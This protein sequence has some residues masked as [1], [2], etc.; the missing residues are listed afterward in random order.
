MPTKLW[1]AGARYNA[2]IDEP[3]TDVTA[4]T[5]RPA[6][7]RSRLWAAVR[8]IVVTGAILSVVALVCPGLFGAWSARVE[9]A[10]P[11]SIELPWHWQ[12]SVEKDPPGLAAV[13]ATTDDR[14]PGGGMLV[15]IAN[16]AG[17]AYDEVQP[18]EVVGRNGV[19][20]SLYP[21]D[22]DWLAGETLH[23]SP[24]GRYLAMPYLRDETTARQGPTIVDLTTGEARV[25][26]ATAVARHGTLAVLGWRP[27]GG[28]LLVATT[29]G[30]TARLALLD[31]TSG[32]STEL[33]EVTAPQMWRVA[34]SPDGRRVA[35]VAGRALHLVDDRGTALWSAPLPTGTDLAGAGAF[36]P[37]GTR[38]ALAYA[39]PCEPSCA[40]GAAEWGVTYVDSTDGTPAAGPELPAVVGSRI[41][42]VGWSARA[43]GTT[44]LVVVRYLP[45]P[46]E[47]PVQ[48]PDGKLTAPPIDPTGDG[49][50]PA[51]LCELAPGGPARLLLDAPHEVTDL[52]VAVELVRA[53]RFE[54]EPSTPSLLPIEPGRL[55]P[56]DVA[57]ASAVV[58]GLAVVVGVV[59]RLTNR[60]WP[61]LR[62]LRPRR[63]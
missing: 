45:D 22:G 21:G 47:P 54:G 60:P 12:G 42:A 49:T 35:F 9:D 11:R 34:F 50:G 6:R 56:V 29:R 55:R 27:D 32:T 25:V 5:P 51:D 59:V 24:D 44:S 39:T 19:Y 63:R 13:V 18:V 8:A 30:R 33:A 31:V 43:D 15:E 41:R 3:A 52:D 48:G 38:I 53:G 62:R 61:R 17:A 7:G 28:A 57:V 23:L 16:R 26:R 20:R 58:G 46:P 37:D 14:T 36:T 40:V 1:P 4:P 10:I 2:P